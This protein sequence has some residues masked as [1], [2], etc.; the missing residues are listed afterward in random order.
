VQ[1]VFVLLTAWIGIDFLLF[2]RQVTAGGAVTVTRPAG[3]E[4]FLP[5]SALMAL[6]RLLVTGLWDDVHP[7][8]LALLI[9]FLLGGVLARRAF[10]SWICPIGTLSRGLEVVR[11]RLL[12]LPPR[13]AVPTWARRY[14]PMVKYPL[15]AGFLWISLSMPVDSIDLF[16][17]APFN[18]GADAAMLRMFA[19][20]SVTG[21]AV[22]SFLVVLSLVLRNGWCRLLCPYG[23]LFAAAGALSP[24]HVQRDPAACHACGACA[25][26]CGMGIAVDHLVRVRSAECTSCLSCLSVCR[27]DGALGVVGPTGRIR[28]PWLVPAGALAI[29]ALAYGL[30]QATGHWQSDLSLAA[31]RF[32]YLM[33]GAGH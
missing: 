21:M 12:R 30:A 20:L 22:L 5:I 25:R 32:A 4:A 29:L 15:L 7:A 6:K 1:G 14:G 27:F 19:E 17:H 28:R 16:L 2:F 33:A 24:F 31:Y 3:V 18:L 10:C 11:T 13:W 8:G 23:A 9:A 26:A